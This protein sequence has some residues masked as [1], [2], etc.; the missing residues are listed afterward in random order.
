MG[1]GIGIECVRCGQQ[2]SYGNMPFDEE[3]KV[4]GDCVTET[5]KKKWD[6]EN[7]NYNY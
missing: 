1:L 3:N 7:A 4:C 5:R 2:L 6:S